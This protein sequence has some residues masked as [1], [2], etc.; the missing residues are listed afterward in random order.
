MLRGAGTLILNKFLTALFDVHVC[1]YVCIYV[2]SLF[3]QLF[4][5]YLRACMCV[6]VPSHKVFPLAKSARFLG[7]FSQGTTYVCS[8]FDAV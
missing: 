2:C 7:D 6:S 8:I 4:K 5:M 3:Q 1:L